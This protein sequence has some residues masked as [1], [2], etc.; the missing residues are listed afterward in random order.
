[1][2]APSDHWHGGAV[3]SREQ[4]RASMQATIDR[5][6]RELVRLRAAVDWRDRRIGDLELRLRGTTAPAPDVVER[7][8]AALEGWRPHT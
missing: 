7:L 4:L 5:Q 1:M 8:R 2:T 6:A 3:Y